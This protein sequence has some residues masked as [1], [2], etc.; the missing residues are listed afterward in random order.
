MARLFAGVD[1]FTVKPGTPHTNMMHIYVRSDAATLTARAIELAR[2]ERVQ[3]ITP[4]RDTELPGW[5]R[6][7]LTI[8]DG[9][10]TIADGELAT[11]IPQLR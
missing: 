7:E 11:L 10:A 8:G 5:S 1:G 3:L 9:A 6:F 4:P 2:R